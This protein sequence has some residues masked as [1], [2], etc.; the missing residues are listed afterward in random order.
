MDDEGGGIERA[1]LKSGDWHFPL[2][3]GSGQYCVAYVGAWLLGQHLLE[4]RIVER[5]KRGGEAT[6][7]PVA[8]SCVCFQAR[9][10]LLSMSVFAF[11]EVRISSAQALNGRD[12]SV[13][14]RCF[15][16]LPAGRYHRQDLY[17]QQPT[18][19]GGSVF[20]FWFLLRENL[21]L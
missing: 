18:P 16:L 19:R 15:C 14:F 20:F 10:L 1:A 11:D 2:F 6:A 7:G 12:V 17:Y 9:R 4:R 13:C 21:D 5:R 3:Y 8:L